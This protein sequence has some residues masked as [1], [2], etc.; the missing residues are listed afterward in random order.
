MGMLTLH[1]S[2]QQQQQMLTEP[3]IIILA[4]RRRSGTNARKGHW[5]HWDV[6]TLRKEE[7]TSI[8]DWPEDIALL[9]VKKLS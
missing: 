7:E 4:R 9:L 3:S 1:N 5:Y 6:S 2:Q 8:E